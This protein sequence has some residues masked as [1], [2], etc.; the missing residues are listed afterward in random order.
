MK[1]QQKAFLV[2]AGT[3]LLVLGSLGLYCIFGGKMASADSAPDG[4]AYR[5]VVR[6]VPFSA[7][8][9]GEGA[10]FEAVLSNQGKKV[11]GHSFRWSSTKIDRVEVKWNGPSEFTI[12]F[13]GM[14]AQNR[15][16]SADNVEWDYAK[17]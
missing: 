16:A 2:V 15:I 8:P 3:A 10:T 5:V 14:P 13:N 7:D 17:K 9:V 12:Y 1:R 4:S 11:S 6:R